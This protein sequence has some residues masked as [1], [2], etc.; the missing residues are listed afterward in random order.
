M[1]KISIAVTCFLGAICSTAFAE[2]NDWYAEAAYGVSNVTDLSYDLKYTPGFARLT[3]GKVVAENWAIE[4]LLTQGVTSSTIAYSSYTNIKTKTNTGY[5]FAVRP[6]MKVT[7]NLELYGRVGWMQ[8]NLN[9]KILYASNG[10]TYSST[11]FS[12]SQYLGSVGVAYKIN[13]NFSATLDYT[14][15]SKRGDATVTQTAIGV[16]YNF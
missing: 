6:F 2:N 11:D 1:K 5:G 15:F 9:S 13:Q 16:R 10:A 7:D 4:G 14:S 3:V 12:W 8:N